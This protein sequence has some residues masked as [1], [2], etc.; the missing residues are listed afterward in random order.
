[1]VRRQPLPWNCFRIVP[2]PGISGSLGDR[3]TFFVIN[4]TPSW[5]HLTNHV[6]R[7][8]LLFQIGEQLDGSKSRFTPGYSRDPNPQG[9][10]ARR[11]AWL[12][13]PVAYPADFSRPPGDSARL[14]LHRSV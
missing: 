11:A 1:M 6:G 2:D 9:R 5:R 10:L 12:R 7:H 13:N 3:P 4:L 14:L 8:T